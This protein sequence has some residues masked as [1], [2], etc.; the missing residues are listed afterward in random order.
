MQE[1]Y[2]NNETSKSHRE[3][4]LHDTCNQNTRNAK[5][6]KKGLKRIWNAFL[7]S[8]D[9]FRAAWSDEAAFRQIVGLCVIF[10]PLA[11]WIAR[12]WQEGVLLL[13]PCFLALMAEL[14]NSAI[15]NAVDYTGI[16]IHPLAKKAKDMGSAV[17]FL[18][19]TFWVCVWV[20]YGVMR[21]LE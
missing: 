8:L 7:Y 11:L 1:H 6:G 16:E 9:G 20:W 12:D 2:T 15:E 10:I 5:K 3:V 14:I 19:L 21:F 4:Y 17:Q 18:A 13:L